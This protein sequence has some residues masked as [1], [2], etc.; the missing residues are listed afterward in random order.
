M[1]TRRE[2]PSADPCSVRSRSRDR[3]A[4]RMRARRASVRARRSVSFRGRES[5]D[6]GL[7]LE[8]RCKNEVS[9]C[10]GDDACDGLL[11]AV[12]ACAATHDARCATIHAA[13]EGPRAIA[14]RSRRASWIY[15][16]ARASKRPR[17]RR[18][19]AARPAS[20]TATRARAGS[21]RP[22]SRRIRFSAT[23]RPFPR[24]VAARRRAGR[25]PA[26]SA[27]ARGRVPSEY[28]R[29]LVSSQRRVQS[30]RDR[31]LRRRRLLR[32]RSHLPLQQL[33]VRPERDAGGIV[34]R[35][36]DA[37]RRAIR[38]G[39]ALLTSL[40]GT[41]ARR[42]REVSRA[43][44]SCGSTRIGN[45]R[46]RRSRSARV[47][48]IEGHRH[49]VHGA[50]G[51]VV[52]REVEDAT[53]TLLPAAMI[54]SPFFSKM[55]PSNV[56]VVWSATTPD[57]VEALVD[58]RLRGTTCSR[59]DRRAAMATMPWRSQSAISESETFAVDAETRI[60]PVLPRVRR[61][62]R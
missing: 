62:W 42:A 20:A 60:A 39:R 36:D 7:C 44:S 16:A 22:R 52:V 28:R 12:E 41:A 6:C 8:R 33:P 34:R 45:P 18:R 43:S 3:D 17:R 9:A 57:E 30:E 58:A 4:A 61:R 29:L 1:K 48:R 2:A 38:R 5:T 54:P 21:R 51:H 31:D 53:L 26:T 19:T 23:G 32:E 59:G 10:C 25:A 13:S 56:A 15:A 14:R 35:R 27:H 40:T 46:R 24:R 11:A 55:Q 37:L 49:A 47:A 50:K